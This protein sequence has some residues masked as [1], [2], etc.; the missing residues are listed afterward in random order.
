MNE[1]HAMLQIMNTLANKASNGTY[2][3]EDRAKLD[4]EF[5]QLKRE[6]NSIAENTNFNGINVLNGNRQRITT[7]RIWGKVD[8][9]SDKHFYN[10]AWSGTQYLAVGTSG[11]TL[12]SYDGTTWFE[13]H[14]PVTSVNL[15][16]VKWDVSQ[17]I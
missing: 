2:S 15:H 9:G 17:F 16:S 13:P 7:D 3:S 14:S 6:K 12:S 11:N 10:I 5:Q 1:I 8:S 4:L